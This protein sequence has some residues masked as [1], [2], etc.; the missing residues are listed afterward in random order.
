MTNDV[1]VL[2][3]STLWLIDQLLEAGVTGQIGA[4]RYERTETRAT[5]RNGSLKRNWDTRLGRIPL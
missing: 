4:S 1:S 5:Q 3:E 2:K